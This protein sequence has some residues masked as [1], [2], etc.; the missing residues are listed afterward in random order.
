MGIGEALDRFWSRLDEDLLLCNLDARLI[1]QAE[2]ATSAAIVGRVQPFGGEPL[3]GPI[4]GR[5]CVYWTL[6][7]FERSAWFAR[8]HLSPEQSQF[9]FAFDKQDCRLVGRAASAVVELRSSAS[10]LKAGHRWRP[11]WHERA[12]T[13]VERY[14]DGLGEAA[15]ARILA[16]RAYGG[17]RM[18]Y[19]EHTV[20]VGAVIA[21]CGACRWEVATDGMRQAARV[22]RV[23]APPNGIL[24][25]RASSAVQ[26]A[27]GR[28]LPP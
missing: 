16:H 11:A 27:F 13:T 8:D 4:S 25:V 15:K 1:D 3:R 14:L 28:R 17:H 26:A 2:N 12:A 21:V 9:H 22:L 24:E 5:A 23:S 6:E 19:V 18:R 20:P 7:L 10:D